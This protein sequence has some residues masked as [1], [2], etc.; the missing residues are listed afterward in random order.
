MVRVLLFARARDL[1]G[2]DSLELELP[3]GASVR[4]LRETLATQQPSL[5]S[6]MD[7]CAVALDH[8]YLANDDTLPDGAT[9]A[10]IPPVSGGSGLFPPLTMSSTN[11]VP[12]RQQ[13]I[14]RKIRVKRRSRS[15]RPDPDQSILRRVDWLRVVTMIVGTVFLAAVALLFIQ[16]V[17]PRLEG[18]LH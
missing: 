4:M 18:R 5:A 2:A 11:H 8:D 3:A 12:Q 9:V 7:R 1:V 13:R 16:A 14:R 17:L 6:M 15:R 10:L